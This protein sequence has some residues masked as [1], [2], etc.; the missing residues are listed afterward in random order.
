MEIKIYRSYEAYKS[1]KVL[2]CARV[3]N[4]DVF[5]FEKS[6]DVFRSIYGTNVIIVFFCV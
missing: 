6:L 3:E 1:G 5:S 2:Y 4:P